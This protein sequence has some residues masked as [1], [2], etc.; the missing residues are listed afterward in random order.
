MKTRIIALVISA[1]LLIAV[2]IF[3]IRLSHKQEATE[4]TA[5]SVQ[6]T[7]VLQTTAQLT[8]TE[9][10][11]EKATAKIIPIATTTRNT[12]QGEHTNPLGRF[13]VTGYTAEEGFPQ[14]SAT[15]SGVGCR[16]GICAMNNAQRM[17]LGIQY[18]D[19]IY[20]EGLGSYQVQDCGCAYGVIDIWLH[21][22]AQAYAITG[23]YEVFR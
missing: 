17:E 21:T 23:H 3:N 5:E 13:K 16:P 11:T 22:D 19:T 7:V 20:I 18:G 10:T 1:L 9:T 2:I 12:E 8:H 14:G 15:A 4:T 6:Q